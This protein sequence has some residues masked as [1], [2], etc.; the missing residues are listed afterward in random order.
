MAGTPS[1][2]MMRDETTGRI[3]GGTV[4]L[5][6]GDAAVLTRVGDVP[7]RI[8]PVADAACYLV[9][10]RKIGDQIGLA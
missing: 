5:G 10:L 3:S 2:S 9:L 8:A 4:T 7:C 6:C 1:M